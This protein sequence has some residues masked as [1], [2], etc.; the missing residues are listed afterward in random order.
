VPNKLPDRSC[1]WLS[2][3]IAAVES[4]ERCV[5]VTVVEVRGSAPR[6]A[7]SRML[8]QAGGF[9]GSIGGGHLEWKAQEAALALLGSVNPPSARLLHFALGPSLGQCC[10]GRVTVL[11]ENL[12][13]DALAWLRAWQ[14]PAKESFLVTCVDPY[15]KSVL[16]PGESNGPPHLAA[17]LVEL[18]CG[19][20]SSVLLR[21]EDGEPCYFVERM[22]DGRLNLYLFGAGH[23]G[24]ALTQI[25]ALLPYRICWF[26]GRAEMFPAMLPANVEAEI[27]AVPRHDVAGAPPGSFFL[28]MTHSHALDFDI[29]DQV[30]R[31]GDFAFLGLIGSAGK[32][33]SFMRRLQSRGHTAAALEGLTCPIGLPQ[34]KGKEPGVIAVAVAGQ[35]LALPQ[36][37][38]RRG[39][40]GAAGRRARTLGA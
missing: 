37:Q 40:V 2:A 33:A 31:R 9:A 14:A 26:D 3:A 13:L 35:L 1:E 39:L 34:V 10:G 38:D 17:A 28:V 20:G 30:L 36:A 15:R 25:L 32:R 11:L 24:R 4:G 19:E 27:S 16:A 12:T 7:G 8:V 29:C 5:L 6:E 23:V 18:S 21:G 22:V